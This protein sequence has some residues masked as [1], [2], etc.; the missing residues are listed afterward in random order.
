MKNYIKELK[1]LIKTDEDVKDDLN[2]KRNYNRYY[3]HLVRKNKVKLDT[4]SKIFIIDNV[5]VKI[6]E[7]K[8]IIEI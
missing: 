2:K 1:K 4:A 8:F 7:G 3:Y 6:E 5:I